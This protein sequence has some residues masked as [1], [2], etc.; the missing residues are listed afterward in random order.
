[1]WLGHLTGT[2]AWGRHQGELGKKSLTSFST[3]LWVSCWRLPLAKLNQKLEFRGL[4]LGFHVISFMCTEQSTEEWGEGCRA[5]WN[6]PAQWGYVTFVVIVKL[7]NKKQNPF[8][9]LNAFIYE[10]SSLSPPSL[11]T[12]SLHNH[13]FLWASTAPRASPGVAVLIMWFHPSC[14]TCLIPHTIVRSLRAGMVFYTTLQFQH[15]V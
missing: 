7:I 10:S 4:Q 6:W 9:S 8:A 5:S 14:L 12:S 11:M 3:T 1:M 15:Q 2:L 13:T